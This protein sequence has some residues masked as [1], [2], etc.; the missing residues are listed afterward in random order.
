MSEHAFVTSSG[1]WTVDLQIHITGPDRRGRC[2]TEMV[3]ALSRDD[4]E[5]VFEM[6]LDDVEYELQ[7]DSWPTHSGDVDGE[8]GA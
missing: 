7:R 3:E 5:V 6:M 8:R 2:V 1:R 4:L